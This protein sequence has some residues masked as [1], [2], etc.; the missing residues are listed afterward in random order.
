MKMPAYLGRRLVSDEDLGSG[1]RQKKL[2]N[3]NELLGLDVI[4]Y[5]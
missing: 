2:S 1:G 4:L 3:D 5:Q